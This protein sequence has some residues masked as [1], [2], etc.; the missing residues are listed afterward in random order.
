MFCSP[1]ILYVENCCFFT[2]HISSTSRQ[3]HENLFLRS[4]FFQR[5]R[6]CH[7]IA[8]NK[9]GYVFMSPDSTNT[10]DVNRSA[11]TNICSLGMQYSA[12]SVC[13]LMRS[14]YCLQFIDFKAHIQSTSTDHDSVLKYLKYQQPI[15]NARPSR[16][17]IVTYTC[18]L[19]QI[20]PPWCIRFP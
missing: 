7:T 8:F 1:A 4:K 11:R 19:S 16:I 15:V 14:R 20:G 5:L 18:L 13:S 12:W 10:I 3:T 2:A 6:W 9:I 17:Q